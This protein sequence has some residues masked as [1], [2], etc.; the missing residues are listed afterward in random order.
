ML[1]E[2][3]ANKS[4]GHCLRGIQF[5]DEGQ[6]YTVLT[7]NNFITCYILSTLCI[8][9]RYSE[10]SQIPFGQ[11]QAYVKPNQLGEITETPKSSEKE[12]S[13][14]LTWL[15]RGTKV[16]S[17]DLVR[18]SKLRPEYPKC[19]GDFAMFLDLHQQLMEPIKL[20]RPR[21]YGDPGPW[22]VIT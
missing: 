19:D 3:K 10:P 11:T 20:P 8:A 15:T 7:C 4:S 21:Q 9:Y 14:Q 16:C 6:F 5:V 17:I 1:L 2:F 22:S 18:I 13:R 12:P